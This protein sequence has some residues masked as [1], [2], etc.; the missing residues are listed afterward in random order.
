MFN[1][2]SEVVIIESIME[3]LNNK[4]KENNVIFL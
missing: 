3:F 2:A 1:T 4:Y